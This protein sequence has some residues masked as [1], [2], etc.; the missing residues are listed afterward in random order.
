MVESLRLARLGLRVNDDPLARKTCGKASGLCP[1]EGL[2]WCDDQDPFSSILKEIRTCRRTILKSIVIG[3]SVVTI[4]LVGTALVSPVK[5]MHA[6]DPS[7]TSAPSAQAVDE[8][9]QVTFSLPT[10][11]ETQKFLDNFQAEQ[12][13][14]KMADEA[15]MCDKSAITIGGKTPDSPHLTVGAEI[16]LGPKGSSVDLNGSASTGAITTQDPAAPRH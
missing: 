11:E 16:C 12:Q 2:I 3:K 10:A 4:V 5:L 14:Q 9:G 7:T 6:S 15:P 8:D 13:R 1:S